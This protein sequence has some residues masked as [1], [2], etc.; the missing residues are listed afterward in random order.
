MFGWTDYL[1]PDLA[2]LNKNLGKVMRY[3]YV[4]A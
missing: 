4:L 3:I 1:I 2:R